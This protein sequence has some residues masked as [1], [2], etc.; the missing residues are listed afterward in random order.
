MAFTQGI[1]QTVH[2]T[3]LDGADPVLPVN[4]AVTVSL[5]GGAT[6]EAPDNAAVTTAY[7]I[8]L[9]LSAAETDRAAV[10][11]RVTADN[12]DA[13]VV[14]FYFEGD[15][16]ATRAGY[17]DDL[18]GIPAAVDAELSTSHGA[19]VW[20]SGSGFGDF[21]VTLVVQDGDGAA[22]PAC[23]VRVLNAGGAIV[24]FG[25]TNTATGSIL[26][27][28]GAGVHTVNLGPMSAYAP[29]NPY[30][31]TVSADATE[32]LVVSAITIPTPADPAL[33][34]VYADMRYA[35]GGA[36]LGAGEGSLNVIQVV[37]RPEG[38]TEVLADDAANDDPALTDGSG[39][40]A[41]SIIR[42]AVVRVKATWPDG[43]FGTVQL[44]VPDQDAYDIGADL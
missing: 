7:G 19:G 34:V 43:R 30:S 37:S 22:V 15:Y 31:I 41:L 5:D 14:A 8:S 1:A 40:A 36:L 44:T 13:Q 27:N 21:A 38:S 23:P 16:T 9:E 33:C 20:G 12:A 17:L 2:I 4:P 3:T 28:L 26:V 10:L 25:I 11:V 24:A 35:A 29:A 39:R 6:F 18:P 32:T 42:G